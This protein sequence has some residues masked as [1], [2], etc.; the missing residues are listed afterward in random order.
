MLRYMLDTDICIHVLRE[1]PASM[2]ER[3]R[4]TAGSLCIS[5]ITLSELFYGAMASAQPEVKRA[6]VEAFAAR[7]EI[8]PYDDVAADHFSD[9][10]AD[11]KRRGCLIG[12]YDLLI[13]AHA[14]SLGLMLITGNLREFRRVD[15][16][17]CESWLEA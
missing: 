3:F 6:K 14:R 16:L 15:G 11:L 7:L 10:K 5:T 8:L 4:E 9:I 12:P 13:A 2:R 17:R 1:R